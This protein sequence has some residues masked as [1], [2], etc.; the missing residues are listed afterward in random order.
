MVCL[1]SFEA[2]LP[3]QEEWDALVERVGGD[4]FNTFDWCATWWKHFGRRRNL[5]IHIARRGDELVAVWPLFREKLRWGPLSLR[6]VRVVGCDHG[7][8]TCNLS[9]DSDCVHAVAS[10]IVS[11]LESDGP[12]DLLHVGEIP[13]YAGNAAAL[14]N[15]FRQSPKVRDV[16][17]EN[18]AYPH[19]V[20]DVPAD[21]EAYLA[22]LSVKERRNV[23]R[24]ERELAKRGG[25]HHEPRTGQELDA[26][27][28]VL[29]DLH[30]KH[31]A[32]RGRHGLFDD[33]PGAEA[34]HRE[35]A[36]KCMN[37]GRLALIE[38]K[39]SEGTIAS[40]YAL[41]FNKR[42]H[43][44][45]GGRREDVT[46]RIGFCALMHGGVRDGVT[47]ID[48]LPG[49]Y[50]YKRRLGARSLSIKMISVLPRGGRGAMRLAM[51]RVVTQFIS[52]VYH[53]AW[54]WHLAPWLA[55]KA[56]RVSSIAV[57]PGL[58]ERFARCRFLVVARHQTA[59]RTEPVCES[60]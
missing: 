56:P 1:D 21:Y 33:V 11:A 51:T 14:V 49:A 42:L 16:N 36:Q 59:G 29:I 53:R 30:R 31:W 22:G 48:G 43:W 52:L 7:V 9:T 39:T 45:I 47:L 26:A 13:G 34:F 25:T 20:F 58:W 3:M 23:R 10:A 6:V 46:S 8:T 27:F 18:N 38:V 19:A 28:D 4:V 15:G 60:E 44:I 55:R 17:F 12:W 40:E 37:S 57:R 24:D 54:F 5:A 32:V 50:D 2:A 35:M 41:R